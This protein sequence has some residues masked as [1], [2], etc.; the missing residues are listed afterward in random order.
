MLGVT[1][2]KASKIHSFALRKLL[3]SEG[4]RDVL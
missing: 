4:N 1:D 2:I 3:V